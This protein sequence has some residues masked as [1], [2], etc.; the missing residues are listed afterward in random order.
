MTIGTPATYNLSPA[1]T[2]V[3]IWNFFWT[4]IEVI[5]LI[6]LLILSLTI[7]RTRR[8]DIQY[9]DNQHNGNQHKGLIC[10]TRQNVTRDKWHSA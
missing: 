5:L 6:I 4:L 7:F 10:V 3:K 1:P 8:H 9:N 2:F